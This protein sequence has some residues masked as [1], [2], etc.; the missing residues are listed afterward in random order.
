MRRL[1]AAILR[2]TRRRRMALT[3][4]YTCST[5]HTRHATA[6]AAEKCGGQ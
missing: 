6:E 5:C 2:L 4:R 3:L 1:I